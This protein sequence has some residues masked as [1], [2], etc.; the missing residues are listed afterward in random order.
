MWAPLKA[1]LF[2][3]VFLLSR[4]WSIWFHLSFVFTKRNKSYAVWAEFC[5]SHK[6]KILHE[7]GNKYNFSK[8]H[9]LNQSTQITSIDIQ[10]HW[11]NQKIKTMIS[12]FLFVFW[13]G[14]ATTT[15]TVHLPTPKTLP[16]AIVVGGGFRLLV[17]Y[18]LFQ[19][20]GRRSP[21]QNKRPA[22]I[23]GL[24]FEIWVSPEAAFLSL[25][26]PVQESMAMGLNER[27][28]QMD[29]PFDNKE[30]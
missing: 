11:K 12:C 17:Y 10:K 20:V 16:T 27:S 23:E 1:F 15:R 5:A 21:R 18:G 7:N 9:K 8:L 14:R 4:P 24:S 13:P 22:R 25:L 19:Q 3:Y 6:S 2:A 28:A 26:G 30:E 29:V